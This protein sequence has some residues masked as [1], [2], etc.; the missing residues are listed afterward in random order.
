MQ[1]KLVAVMGRPRSG[2][3]SFVDL[4]RKAIALLRPDLTTGEA[5][6]IDCVRH[7][8]ANAGLDMSAK[9]PTDRN[10]LAGIGHML[11]EGYNFPTNSVMKVLG[12]GPGS[13]NADYEPPDVLFVQV[14][15]HWLVDK[16]ARLLAD[17]AYAK[18]I[19]REGL[20]DLP[21]RVVRLLVRTDADYRPVG[22][23][24]DDSDDL[25]NP[26]K[27]DRVVAND[28]TW[29]GLF[30][31]A[32]DFARWITLPPGPEQPKTGPNT[33]GDRLRRALR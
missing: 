30:E 10:T 32:H 28:M 19:S 4:A 12:R 31:K 27:Y 5:S 21:A 11:E 3:D 1:Q 23:A 22:N 14:R 29:P 17:R 20:V 16:W 24:S 15:E 7:M 9:T 25:D 6:S 13:W 8:L 2:K 33:I 26:L 18:R